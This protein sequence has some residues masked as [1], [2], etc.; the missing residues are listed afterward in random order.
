[1][2]NLKTHAHLYNWERAPGDSA[3]KFLNLRWFPLLS[4]SWV[5][6]PLPLWKSLWVSTGGACGVLS[7]FSYPTVFSRCPISPLSPTHTH[8]LLPLVVNLERINWRGYLAL[9]CPSSSLEVTACQW[10][11]TPPCSSRTRTATVHST[12]VS[13]WICLIQ[14]SGLAGP[15]GS[16]SLVNPL[17]QPSSTMRGIF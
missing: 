3:W 12:D 8:S 10:E 2:R 16:C 15:L 17:T 13:G 11:R 1:M 4:S 9:L 5:L 14:G 7:R 6:S